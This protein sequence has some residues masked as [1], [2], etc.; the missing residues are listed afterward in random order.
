MY[1]SINLQK[2]YS[3]SSADVLSIC[4]HRVYT[5]FRDAL[6]KPFVVPLLQKNGYKILYQEGLGNL[7]N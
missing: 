3:N 4:I 2:P 5:Y 1:Q 7:G 6:E